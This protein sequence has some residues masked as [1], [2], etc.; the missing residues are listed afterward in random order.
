MLHA[1][2]AADGS[3]HC[4]GGAKP[5]AGFPEPDATE[6]TARR[7]PGLP[8]NW[9]EVVGEALSVLEPGDFE[10]A[11]RAIGVA[12]RRHACGRREMLGTDPRLLMLP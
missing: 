4:R 12:V 5:P 10:V 8:T 7:I 3:Q 6:A 1:H 11:W 2:R 9:P